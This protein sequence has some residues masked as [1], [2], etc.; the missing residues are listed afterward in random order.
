VGMP[1]SSGM[2]ASLPHVK[3]NGVSPLLVLID[4][5]VCPLD[6]SVNLW[7]SNDDVHLLDIQSCTPTLERIIY[8]LSTIVCDN[9][10]EK[11]KLADY[12]RSKDVHTPLIEWPQGRDGSHE[13]FGEL[14]YS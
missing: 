8:K 12:E 6:Q 13:G 3:L 11:A 5:F 14:G 7:V 1:I 4:A 10:P 9:Y 2:T